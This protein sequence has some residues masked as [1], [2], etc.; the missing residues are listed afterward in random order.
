M[1]PIRQLNDILIKA[2][3]SYRFVTKKSRISEIEKYFVL[4]LSILGRY[5]G[6]EEGTVVRQGYNSNNP[7]DTRKGFNLLSLTEEHEAP[8]YNFLRFSEINYGTAIVKHNYI[9]E[10]M[11]N[12]EE[13]AQLMFESSSRDRFRHTHISVSVSDDAVTKGQQSKGFKGQYSQNKAFSSSSVSRGFRYLETDYGHWN[14]NGAGQ[15]R[16]YLNTFIMSGEPRDVL[17][18]V[19][20]A[21]EDLFNSSAYNQK[22]E[23]GGGSL[24]PEEGFD[25]VDSDWPIDFARRMSQV[26]YPYDDE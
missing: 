14:S 21:G 4:I 11:L 10:D 22:S 3:N 13:D 12:V 18:Q 23:L 19:E 2:A 15:C 25:Y 9:T 17:K 8:N 5:A 26:N 20:Q 16:A 24:L 6:Q 7:A 1:I